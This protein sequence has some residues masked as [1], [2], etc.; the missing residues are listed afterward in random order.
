MC[1]ELLDDRLNLLVASRLGSGSI[2]A[3]IE[4]SKTFKS[5]LM[6]L[7]L[8]TIGNSPILSE[9]DALQSLLDE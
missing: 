8:Q 2:K 9:S 4:H 5:R 7:R 1:A 3:H 6:L